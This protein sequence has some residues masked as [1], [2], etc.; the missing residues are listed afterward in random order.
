[1]KYWKEMYG[2][3]SKEFIEGVIAGIEAYA[4]WKDGKQYVGCLQQPKE[5]I[6][7]EVKEQLGWKGDR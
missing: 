2:E 7:K 6:I 3:R 1:M 4:I 5:E